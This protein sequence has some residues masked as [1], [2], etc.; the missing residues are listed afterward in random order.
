MENATNPPI[1]GLCSKVLVSGDK[2]EDF[3][4]QAWLN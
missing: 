2:Q 1:H 4:T 3:E